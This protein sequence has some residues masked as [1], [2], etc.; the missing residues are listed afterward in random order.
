MENSPIE[1]KVKSLLKEIMAMPFSETIAII[2]AERQ[3]KVLYQ[4]DPTSISILIALLFCNLEQGKREIALGLSNRIWREGGEL[5]DFFE[6]VYT[7]CLLNLGEIEKAY[8]LLQPHL[9]NPQEN[10]DYFY[11]VLVKYALMSGDL[12]LLMQLGEYPDVYQW[13]PELFDFAKNNALNASAQSYRALLN[14]IHS[15]IKQFMCAFEYALY[16]DGI[17]L[18][19]YTNVSAEQNDNWQQ[20][21]SEKTDAYFEENELAEIDGLSVSFLNINEHP[22]WAE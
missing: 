14:I 12:Y 22:A 21:L 15:T 13:E 1:E 2:E 4:Q 3:L 16:D 5:S 9:Q 11:M 20:V 10:I 6:L 7:D 19:F 8:D 17:E 18:L